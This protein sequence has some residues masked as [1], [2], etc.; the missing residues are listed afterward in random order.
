MGVLFVGRMTPSV[1]KQRSVAIRKMVKD[2]FR[3]YPENGSD[4]VKLA[5]ILC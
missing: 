2:I 4:L 1:G 5:M 3:G